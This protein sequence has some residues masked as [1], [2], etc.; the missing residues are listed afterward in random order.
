[1][2]TEPLEQSVLS[3]LPFLPP[4]Q[5]ALFLALKEIQEPVL[6]QTM[7][8]GYSLVVI[9]GSFVV[10]CADDTAS[11]VNEMWMER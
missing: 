9:F 11:I 4:W 6:Q 1:M 5:Q 7:I 3:S 10:I 8:S 2:L